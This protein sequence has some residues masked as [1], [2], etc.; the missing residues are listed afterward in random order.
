MLQNSL[1]PLGNLMNTIEDRKAGGTS[2]K[3]RSLLL[4]P[5]CAL[6]VVTSLS[7]C[8]KS[9]AIAAPQFQSIQAI[10]EA[11]WQ[12]HPTI[13]S[14]RR[15]VNSIDA[16]LRRHAFK[17]EQRKFESCG[18]QYFTLRRIARDSK[19][20][21]VWYEDYGEG[22]DS[23]WDYHYY[24]DN[25]HRLRFALIVVNAANGSREQHRGYYDESG[26]L[27]WQ[28]RKTLKGPGYFRPPDI[29]ELAKRDP[30]REYANDQGCKEI[31]PR[32]GRKK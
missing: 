30:A 2:A 17:S 11:N 20:S 23:A 12:R 3:L 19:G 5:L 21:V 14:I 26:K 8:F 6:T 18:D 27:I 22:E 15:I 25:D 10:T 24:Y 9:S 13:Q 29:D 32:S 31:K 28:N 16:G 1:S 4:T 7:F